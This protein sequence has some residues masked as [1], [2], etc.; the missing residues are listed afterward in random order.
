M[1]LYI[2]GNGFDLAHGLKTTY[3]DFRQYLIEHG[4][5]NYNKGDFSISK[6]EIVDKF[7]EV[8]KPD[9]SWNDFELQTLKI[10]LKVQND[11]ISI[12][13]KEWNLKLSL[14]PEQY[15]FRDSIKEQLEIHKEEFDTS[16]TEKQIKD[17]AMT[18]FNNIVTETYLWIPY[19]YISFQEW[20]TTVDTSKCIF[21][22][23][24]VKNSSAISFNYT[25]TLEEVYS[26]S[27]ILFIHGSTNI[28]KDIV[29]GYH[30]ASIDEELPGLQ[31]TYTED[32]R[33]SQEA[34][35]Q[36]GFKK[37]T[38]NKF[39]NENINRFYKPVNVLKEKIATFIQEKNI[40]VVTVI[41]H[42]YNGID[43]PYFEE[44]MKELPKARYV[45]TFYTPSD[46]KNI[47]EMVKQLKLDIDYEIVH[48][49][50]LMIEK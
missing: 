12:F 25:N 48:T 37:P 22:Y 41:G 49:G 28:L 15:Q 21:L 23:D 9:D 38:S 3:Y 30:S 7:E 17:G 35:S 18:Y 8:C 32:Y 39:Y 46:R 27:D 42:S 24:L 20:I 47:E 11:K 4:E 16:F 19:L 36:A 10:I 29:L 34:S 26:I 1:N 40:D 6:K 2:M 50:F 33:Q 44:V 45:F 43:W 5:E 14:G 13:G 31:T